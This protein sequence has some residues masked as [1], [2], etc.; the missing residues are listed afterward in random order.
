MLVWKNIRS[1]ALRQGYIFLDPAAMWLEVLV[2]TR[3]RNC[4]VG[5]RLAS[6]DTR[7]MQVVFP[8]F[9]FSAHYLLNLK[10]HRH[11]NTFR[12]S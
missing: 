9:I 11:W 5:L 1:Y 3:F 12:C 4:L 6:G 8:C 10:N 2:R 7:L